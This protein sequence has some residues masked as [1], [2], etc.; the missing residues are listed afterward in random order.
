MRRWR[1][2]VEARRRA[3]RGARAIAVQRD[4]GYGARHLLVT[5]CRVLTCAPANLLPAPVTSPA[6]AWRRA[7]PR[8]RAET[9]RTS[10]P[11]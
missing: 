5:T 7:W 4:S 3:S 2:E 6:P 1:Q 8:A 10:A 9:K 11:G